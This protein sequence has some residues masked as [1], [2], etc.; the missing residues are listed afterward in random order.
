MEELT[1]LR[2][3]VSQHRYQEALGLI[4]EME[5]MSRKSILMNIKSYLVRLMVHLIKVQIEQRL[6][7][8]WWFSIRDS[9]L[10]IQELN[11]M[12]NSKSHYIKQIAWQTYLGDALDDAI[13]E[14]S[15]E[16][17]NAKYAP[18]EL[19]QLVDKNQLITLFSEMIA[20]SYRYPRKEL[21]ERVELHLSKLLKVGYGQTPS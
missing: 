3:Y 11:L 21:A 18:K 13:F 5:E 8:S 14:A 17:A 2:E 4:G 7:K 9:I 15:L 20:E 1:Q 19:A 16:V 10:K 6:T 12:E